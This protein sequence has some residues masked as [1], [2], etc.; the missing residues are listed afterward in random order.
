MARDADDLVV[1]RVNGSNLA[2]DECVC[3]FRDA[4][5]DESVRVVELSCTERMDRMNR[6]RVVHIVS[7]CFPNSKTVVCNLSSLVLSRVGVLRGLL[8]IAPIPL[9]P[10]LSYIEYL[11]PTSTAGYFLDNP[12]PEPNPIL[13]LLPPLLSASTY[14]FLARRHAGE[15]NL[16][17][18][19]ICRSVTTSDVI[20]VLGGEEEDGD[21]DNTDMSDSGGVSCA[22]RAWFFPTARG[23]EFRHFRANFNKFPTQSDSKLSLRYL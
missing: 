18:T 1:P 11:R 14:V 15:R 13:H 10:S 20:G 7:G 3:A 4:M 17:S 23:T 19:H 16:R 8:I 22:I 5:K 21:N 12:R 6:E 9:E 2:V